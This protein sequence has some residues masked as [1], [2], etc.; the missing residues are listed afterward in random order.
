MT[1]LDIWIWET[2][3][4]LTYVLIKIEKS[5]RVT[6]IVDTPTIDADGKWN[7]FCQVLRGVTY[8]YGVVVCETRDE[9]FSIKEG[10]ILDT[11]KVR[12]EQRIKN[13]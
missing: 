8:Q 13:V 1:L 2:I 11:E 3:I 12:F 6:K 9:A 5:M 10:Q 4:I 7:V